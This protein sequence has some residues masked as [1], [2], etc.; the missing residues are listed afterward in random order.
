MCATIFGFTDTK[1]LYTKTKPINCNT[2]CTASICFNKYKLYE[3][4]QLTAIAIAIAIVRFVHTAPI[5]ADVFLI[6]YDSLQLSCGQ[7]NTKMARANYE[8]CT[9]L[10]Y[11]CFRCCFEYTTYTNICF[12]IQILRICKTEDR[13]T[14]N[15][16][17]EGLNIEFRYGNNGE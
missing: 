1:N 9:V 16:L 8:I 11:R 15:R 3:R 4:V 7:K 2:N 12:R 5:Y 13:S 10:R 6:F 14:H 17:I